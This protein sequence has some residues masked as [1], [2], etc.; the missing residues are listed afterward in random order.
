VGEERDFAPES[1]T[2]LYQRSLYQ[3]LRGQARRTFSLLRTHR[4]QLPEPVGQKA[5]QVLASEE[6]L[7]RVYRRVLERKLHAQR[8]RCHGDF[9]LGQLLFTGKDFVIID[10]EGE[11]DRSITARRIKTSP[12]RDV[13]G[14]IRSFHYA[15]HTALIGPQTRNPSASATADTIAAWLSGWVRWCTIAYLQAYLAEAAQGEFLPQD[16]DELSILLESYL[17]EKA[18]YE[19]SYELNNRPDWVRIPLEGI[20]QLLSCV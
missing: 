20:L 5:D 4:P 2:K 14:M 9:H 10:F 16:R 13:A 17:L 15:A 19:L 8:T 3:S 18:V 1:F 12:L 7:H 11:P 6:A